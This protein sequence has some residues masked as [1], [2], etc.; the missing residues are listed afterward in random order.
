MCLQVAE[1]DGE[2][3]SGCTALLQITCVGPLKRCRSDANHIYFA[4]DS[5]Q[6][7]K[8]SFGLAEP[9]MYYT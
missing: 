1:K 3:I 2:A 5:T 4:I 7:H 8:Y 9:S 6:K